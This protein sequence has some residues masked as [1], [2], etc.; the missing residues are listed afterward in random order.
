MPRRLCIAAILLAFVSS[1]A[2]QP[3]DP[4]ADLG[5]SE[6]APTGPILDQGRFAPD[7]K[8]FFL[9]LADDTRTP[10]QVCRIPTPRAKPVPLTRH[11]EGV[12]RFDV[13]P[14]GRR[15]AFS[16]VTADR[17]RDLAVCD[18]DG[19][20]T[21]TVASTPEDED[22]PRWLPD[23]R[24]TYVRAKGSAR[25][26]SGRAAEIVLCDAAGQVGHAFPVPGL[27]SRP[28]FSADGARVYF[29]RWK[30][31]TEC[32]WSRA[33]IAIL[34][35][36]PGET[37]FLL[38]ADIDD[39]GMLFDVE[40]SP[41]ERRLAF[42]WCRAPGEVCEV[43]L[44]DLSTREQRRWLASE[45]HTIYIEQWSADGA[46]L[47][48]SYDAPRFSESFLGLRLVPLPEELR[49]PSE[50]PSAAGP[51]GPD[52]LVW[53]RPLRLPEEGP[54]FGPYYR[55]E[56]AR[57]DGGSLGVVTENAT[58]FR[59]T[60]GGRLLV[61]ST[62]TTLM[63]APVVRREVLLDLAAGTSRVLIDFAIN[64]KWPD[65]ADLEGKPLGMLDV[66]PDGRR[67]AEV[68]MRQGALLLEIAE[69]A[70][71]GSRGA[72]MRSEP[73]P[74]GWN[75]HTVVLAPEGS[76]AAVVLH[77]P[78]RSLGDLP[79]AALWLVPAEKGASPRLLRDGHDP[80]WASD[81]SVCYA[82]WDRDPS[83]AGE[84]I[85]ISLDAA[86]LPRTLLAGGVEMRFG[87][88]WDGPGRLAFVEV[89]EVDAWPGWPG[90]LRTLAVEGG[91]AS[92]VV[93]HGVLRFA[94]HPRGWAMFLMEGEPPDPADAAAWEKLRGRVVVRDRATGRD[95]LVAG[96]LP[97]GGHL[98]WSTLFEGIGRSPWTASLGWTWSK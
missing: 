23:G 25:E 42:G 70:K 89:C 82:V 92:D 66:S 73:V 50:R 78:N 71:D 91:A 63:R 52:T 34:E 14:D 62:V 93:A 8:G 54:G 4:G 55:L 5:G 84:I 43:H 96:D 27:T 6:I 97:V 83:R 46:S 12:A 16:F 36:K 67:E 31:E 74:K 72:T 94:P 1:A 77:A 19:S 69:R 30:S 17:K 64:P 7:G 40:P 10:A 44:L 80:L 81:G 59:L 65:P 41:D 68:Y 49:R 18:A 75:P 2:A 24:L 95:A 47:L 86:E 29:A 20:N 9:I 58:G 11:P 76:S 53:L 60:G 79:D 37:E 39:V 51:L 35:G 88:Q 28:A 38:A 56:A 57:A 22:Y 48:V 61:V 21:R 98:L 32:E 26:R 90:A 85:A 13:S 3:D 33:P 87:L 15:F 45:K